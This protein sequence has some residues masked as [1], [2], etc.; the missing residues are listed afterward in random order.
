MI[1]L[2]S[3]CEKTALCVS[4]AARRTTLAAWPDFRIDP[5][6]SR[7]NGTNETA[8]GRAATMARVRFLESSSR[9]ASSWSVAAALSAKPCGSKT[10]RS[11]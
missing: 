7:R 8:C 4:T 11:R 1:T 9:T 6:A 3:V 5:V 2:P 10:L